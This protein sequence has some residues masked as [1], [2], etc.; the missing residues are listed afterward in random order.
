MPMKRRL[1]HSAS[2]WQRSFTNQQIH[3]RIKQKH[4]SPG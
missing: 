1:R 3:N 4:H 2:C